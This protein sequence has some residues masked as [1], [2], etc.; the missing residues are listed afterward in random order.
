MRE[1][2]GKEYSMTRRRLLGVGAMAAVT[3]AGLVEA[4]PAH[5]ATQS[6]SSTLTLPNP[7][8]NGIARAQIFSSHIT[9]PAVFGDLPYYFIWATFTGQRPDII[10]SV[11]RPALRDAGN[12]HPIEWY[13]QNHPDWVMYRADR[14]TPA[15]QPG[16]AQLVPLNFTNPQ[17]RQYYVDNWVTPVASAGWPIIALDNVG[18]YNGNRAA[19]YYD[20]NGNWVQR[21]N[22]DDLHDQAWSDA[23][24]DWMD[25]LTT[26]I[27]AL[28]VGVA[29]NIATDPT[30]DLTNNRAV[31]DM[32][33]IWLDESGFT[34]A[35]AT[36]YSGQLWLNKF[37]F[38]RSIASQ[39]LYVQVNQTSVPHLADG[40][41]KQ[42]NYAI[43]NYMLFREQKSMLALTGYQEYGYFLDIPKLHTSI[44]APTSVPAQDS[45]GA[46]RRTYEHGE[47]IVNS[48]PN[49]TATVSVGAGHWHNLDGTNIVGPTQLSVLPVTGTV[50]TQ[51][52]A[53]RR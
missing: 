8:F 28:D 2:S 10:A 9:D 7:S 31:I 21:F 11:Y 13:Q 36:M 38:I 25:Y 22:G 23:V 50:L 26:Q 40:D 19:G 44:G 51:G 53:R 49:V 35:S 27:H 12:L 29:A 33:D 18:L 3:A 6:T 5:A 20:A 16:S 47:T 15:Y 30:W 45:S 48:S 43:A 34:R 1:E 42:I 39:K 32:V 41:P 17:V 24:A 52:P 46:W 14:Q 4:S 37:N